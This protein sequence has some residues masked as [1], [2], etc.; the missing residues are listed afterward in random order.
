M[1]SFAHAQLQQGTGSSLQQDKVVNVSHKVLLKQTVDQC[2]ETQSAPWLVSGPG[3][4]HIVW[5]HSPVHVPWHT[6]NEPS[7]QP[8]PTTTS[9]GSLSTANSRAA[10]ASTVRPIRC[11][12][13]PRLRRYLCRAKSLSN[14]STAR[15]C[16]H[17]LL[18]VHAVAARIC[19]CEHAHVHCD[20]A[21]LTHQAPQ[22]NRYTLGRLKN[23]YFT[24]RCSVAQ[25]WQLECAAV[26][27]LPARL[28]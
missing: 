12:A 9:E 18:T 2:A 13:M 24:W 8:P 20:A 14:L 3:R 11:S 26:P 1:P 17:T 25:L 4:K 16:M 15:E 22:H 28:E 21:W 23:N 10:R 27:L 7:T 6:A 5:L 19:C